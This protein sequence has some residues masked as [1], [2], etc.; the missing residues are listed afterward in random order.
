[1]TRLDDSSTTSVS[2]LSKA[3]IDTSVIVEY[4]DRKGEYHDQAEAIFDALKAGQLGLIIPHPILAETYYVT[5]TIC[6]KVGIENPRSRAANLIEWLS[7][8]PSVHIPSEVGLDLEAGEAKLEHRIALTD[9]YV[10]AASKVFSCQAVFRCREEEMLNRI[11]VLEKAY[12]VLFLE[13]YKSTP[14]FGSE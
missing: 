13:D 5:A 7:R 6:G 14:L 2:N 1:V 8:H 12:K 10:L 9:C 4:V 3:A 11:G